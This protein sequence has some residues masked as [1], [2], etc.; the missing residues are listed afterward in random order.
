[1]G[2]RIEVEAGAT[3]TYLRRD[4]FTNEFIKMTCASQDKANKAWEQV[5]KREENGVILGLLH[6]GT[7]YHAKA[8]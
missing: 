7:E 2:E 4:A 5:A 8:E 3:F 6:S 1:M